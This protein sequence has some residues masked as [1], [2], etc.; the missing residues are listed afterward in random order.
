MRSP[1]HAAGPHIVDL[2]EG[3]LLGEV[4]QRRLGLPLDAPE[5]GR[6]KAGGLGRAFAG[7]VDECEGVGG[8]AGGDGAGEGEGVVV[9]DFDVLPK[10]VLVYRYLCCRGRMGNVL[11]GHVVL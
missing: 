8:V 7:Y 5:E 4:K 3:V 10:M 9:C 2:E 1:V 6:E 11:L